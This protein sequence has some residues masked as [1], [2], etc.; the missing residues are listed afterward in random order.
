MTYLFSCVG[1]GARDILLGGGNS[2]ELSLKLLSLK[3]SKKVDVLT[4]VRT[5]IYEFKILLKA[6]SASAI[7]V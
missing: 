6:S 4:L 2:I 1:G 3:K 7:F 5:S